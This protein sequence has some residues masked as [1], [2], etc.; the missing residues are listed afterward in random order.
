MTKE[1]CVERFGITQKQFS[2]W[3]Q[4]FKHSF[5]FDSQKSKDGYGDEWMHVL[6]TDG[7]EGVAIIQHYGEC[8]AEDGFQIE[9]I[10][11]SYCDIRYKD[12]KEIIEIFEGFE[13]ESQMRR[14]IADES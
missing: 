6:Y 8:S 3:I 12:M 7:D 9:L 4:S 10:V 13:R 2:E 11:G 14:R 5:L 1:I